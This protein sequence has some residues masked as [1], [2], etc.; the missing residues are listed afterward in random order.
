MI[1]EDFYYPSPFQVIILAGG[2]GTRLMEETATI[3]KPMVE[4]GGKTLL[5]HIIDI[6]SAQGLHEFIVPVGYRGECIF[7]Y[8]ASLFEKTY[9]NSGGAWSGKVGKNFICLVSTGEDTQTGGRIK[10]LQPRINTPFYMTY[11]D[12]LA[13][14]NLNN[15]KQIH[16]DYDAVVTLT[17]VHPL[18]RFGAIT[19]RE[20]EIVRF[21]EKTDY[22]DGWINGG[23]ML[24]SPAIFD[25]IDGD[26]TN[27]ES[28]VLPYLAEHRE[29]FAYQHE[30]FWQCVDTLRDLQYLRELEQNGQRE[31]MNISG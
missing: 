3:P 11:G 12:G 30:G 18:P 6:Y 16:T 8:F 28:D 10:R 26:D 23:F 19:M 7:A 13:N 22:L 27:L 14:V 29:L 17:A 9:E 31:W 24:M 4:I 20:N 2:K 1:A 5:E 25:Y 21:G 15:L